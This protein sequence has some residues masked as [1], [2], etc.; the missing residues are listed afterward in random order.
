M[1]QITT[2]F[3]FGAAP[4]RSVELIAYD[5]DRALAMVAVVLLDRTDGR[6][7]RT[8]ETHWIAPGRLQH[9]AGVAEIF[10]LLAHVPRATAPGAVSLQR[11]QRRGAPR[12]APTVERRRLG[13]ARLP[14]SDA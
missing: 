10:R 3:D 9:P 6:Y 2:P 1:S 12:R 5:P 7:R 4:V 14:Y 11:P 8:A 13:P